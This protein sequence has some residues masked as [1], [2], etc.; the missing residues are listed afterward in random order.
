MKQRQ[1]VAAYNVVVDE[2]SRVLLVRLSDITEAPGHW[3]LPGGGIEFGEHPEAAAIRELHEETGLRGRI[4][5]LLT[6]DAVH[7]VAREAGE[8]FDYHAI[9]IVY[10]T[11]IESADLV[12]EADG[13][14]DMA[15]WFTFEELDEISLVPIAALGSRFAFGDR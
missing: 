10:R 11:E 8:D 4:L 2:H 15:E 13:S 3:T 9:R 14:T 5:E 6:V 7:R 12:H 1:R